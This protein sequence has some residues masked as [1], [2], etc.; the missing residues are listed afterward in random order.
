[1]A[2]QWLIAWTLCLLFTLCTRASS[3]AAPCPPGLLPSRGQLGQS[4]YYDL[5][6]ARLAFKADARGRSPEDQER[7]LAG[8]ESFLS[9]RARRLFSFQARI[10]VADA[11]RKAGKPRA[12]IR[13]YGTCQP[14]GECGNCNRGQR[15]FRQDCIASTYEQA[16]DYPRALGLHLQNFLSALSHDFLIPSNGTLA[17][18]GGLVRTCLVCFGPLLL[19]AGLQLRQMR[20]LRERRRMVPEATETT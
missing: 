4:A 17:A 13:L 5:R 19:I 8:Y 20:S 18:L 16:G 11:Y 3:A 7:L 12:A 2:R 6:L 1:M 9:A 10:A 15:A 14:G